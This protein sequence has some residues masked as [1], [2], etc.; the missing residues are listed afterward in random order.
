LRSAP[1]VLTAPG[2][3]RASLGGFALIR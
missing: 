1:T 3:I 2:F